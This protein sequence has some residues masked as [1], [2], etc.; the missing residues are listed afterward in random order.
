MS[1][2]VIGYNLLLGNINS[3]L[4]SLVSWNRN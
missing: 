3:L 4:I 1:Y 2:T